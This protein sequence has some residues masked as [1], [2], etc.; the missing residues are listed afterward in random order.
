MIYTPGKEYASEV[1]EGT[2][3]DPPDDY[4]VPGYEQNFY[5]LNTQLKRKF[6]Q[7]EDD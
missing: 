1:L 7:E 3:K 6:N 4:P 5:E 2:Y